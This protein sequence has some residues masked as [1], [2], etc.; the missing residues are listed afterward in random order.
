MNP[1]SFGFPQ[2]KAWFLRQAKKRWSHRTHTYP[3]SF[4]FFLL[5]YKEDNLMEIACVWIRFHCQNRKLL[6][7]KIANITLI[8][9][10]YF[11]EYW[12]RLEIGQNISISMCICYK[13]KKLKI[14]NIK[15]FWTRDMGEISLPYLWLNILLMLRILNELFSNFFY[16]WNLK[17]PI[18]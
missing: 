6:S 11:T 3:I 14:S 17:L 1:N 5:F 2:E 13:I 8:Y 12:V 7:S 4:L 16:F 9:E 15:L 18:I 10:I